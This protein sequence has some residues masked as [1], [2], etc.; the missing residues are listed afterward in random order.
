MDNRSSHSI[1]QSAKSGAKSSVEEEES[2]EEEEAEDIL[3][4]PSDLI[5]S[6]SKTTK[7]TL[8]STRG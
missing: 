5:V 6:N 7:S 2:E 1:S 3:I 4:K 8:V